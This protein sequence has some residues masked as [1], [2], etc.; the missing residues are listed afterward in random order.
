MLNF[1]VTTTYE[2]VFDSSET[3][4]RICL[5]F[6]FCMWQWPYIIQLQLTSVVGVGRKGNVVVLRF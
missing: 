4:G 1:C 6:L 3:L 2:N 5:K